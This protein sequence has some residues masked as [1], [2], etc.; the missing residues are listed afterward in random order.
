MTSQTQLHHEH[1]LYTASLMRKQ[2]MVKIIHQKGTLCIPANALSS[3]QRQNATKITD[4]ALGR[5]ILKVFPQT[6]CGLQ[7]GQNN[8][9]CAK[10]RHF[11]LE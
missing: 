7:D 2:K 9:Q 3:K 6:G 4:L 5:M 8:S 1:L 10:I 11:M